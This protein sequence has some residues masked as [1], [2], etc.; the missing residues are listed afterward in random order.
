MPHPFS[1]PNHSFHKLLE[2]KTENYFPRLMMY[3]DLT[4]L[5]GHR[6]QVTNFPDLGPAQFK[7]YRDDHWVNSVVV[8][9]HQSVA[10]HLELALW[11]QAADDWIE[12]LR[13]LPYVVIDC[14]RLG[15]THTVREAHRLNSA[16][17]WT[18][19]D[20][21][22][23]EKFIRELHADIGIISTGKKPKKKKK[24]EG[25]TENAAEV[26]GHLDLRRFYRAVFKRDINAVIHGVFLEK[27]AGRLRMTRLLSGFIDAYHIEPAHSGGVKN[28]H[29]LP[30]PK[31]LGLKA[32]QGF[33]NVPYARTDFSPKQI[34][35]AFK[36]DLDQ[37]NGYG[38][39]QA[40]E[41]LLIAI[42]LL[43]VRRLL[44]RG[45]KPRAN[46]DLTLGGGDIRVDLPTGFVVPSEEILREIITRTMAACQKDE[47]TRFVSPA[48]THL[49]WAR[50]EK[51]TAIEIKL[52]AGVALPQGFETE[53]HAMHL[54]V[55][56]TGKKK[57]TTTIV[58]KEGWTN[59][60]LNAV[61]KAFADNSDVSKLLEEKFA[62]EA[63]EDE[64]ETDDTGEA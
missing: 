42:S 23:T 41:E 53:P 3:A 2:P 22:E 49:T 64:S 6:L 28:D 36:I 19:K 27:V 4:Q 11:D 38:L 8:D 1:N 58:F 61:R 47:P 35:G 43:K 40:A 7:A 51:D 55:K 13:G 9:S 63:E 44:G 20:T 17:I 29:L 48:L 26:P 15:R 34:V 57:K 5:D 62:E 39:G 60:T 24:E 14:G 50:A 12:P 59:D 56:E 18:G 30:S 37:L 45:F 32:E 21:P 33:G 54:E 16:Y 25:G 46:C 52:P 10:N 31:A